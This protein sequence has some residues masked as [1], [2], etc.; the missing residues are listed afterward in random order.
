VPDFAN[1]THRS[2]RTMAADPDI[3]LNTAVDPDRIGAYLPAGASVA[4]AG[5]AEVEVTWTPD[6]EAQRYAVTVHPDEH[7]ARWRPVDG[8]G[9]PGGLRVTDA[10]AGASEVELFV[11]AGDADANA[12]RRLLDEALRGLATEVDQNFNVS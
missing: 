6:G 8:G 7:T 5:A 10:G 4:D 12:V 1:N 11:E 9:W 2:S 3:V